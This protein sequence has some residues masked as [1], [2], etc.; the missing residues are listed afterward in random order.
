MNEIEFLKSLP[1]DGSLRELNKEELELAHRLHQE[2]KAFMVNGLWPSMMAS[3]TF[4]GRKVLSRA[5]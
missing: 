1:T 2:K 3:I 5:E 4:E